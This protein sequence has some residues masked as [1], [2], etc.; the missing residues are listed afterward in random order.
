MHTLRNVNQLPHWNL[1]T[2]A[3]RG[4]VVFVLGTAGLYIAD[5]LLAGNLANP[6]LSSWALFRSML[7]LTAPV[8]LL[9]LDHVI[10]RYPRRPSQLLALLAVQLCMT[11]ALAAVT[12]NALGLPVSETLL[13]AVVALAVLLTSGGFFRSQYR[14]SLALSTIQLWKFAFFIPI[15][16]GIVAGWELQPAT[17]AFAT[18]G[19]WSVA[20][21]V[22]M[23]RYPVAKSEFS[24]APLS[25]L[26]SFGIRF[27]ATASL[28]SVIAFVDQLIL[29]LD[30]SAAESA[31]YFS[32]AAAVLPPFLALA[33]LTAN[34]AN[35]YLRAHASDIRSRVPRLLVAFSV[36]GI[37]GLTGSMFSALVLGRLLGA[38]SRQVDSALL[39]GLLGVGLMR[40]LYVA[41]SAVIGMYG[42]QRDLDRQ[43]L[44][45][46]VSMATGALGYVGSRTLGISSSGAVLIF[47]GVTLLGRNVSG[48]LI[49]ARILGSERDL[50]GA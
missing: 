45:T 41:P 29:N 20:A 15:A 33:G 49:S 9:G 12:L 48:A 23:I 26:Y 28:S 44:F 11:I 21:L 4:T 17:V 18:L 7:F 2:D 6:D 43:L 50:V 39:F 31:V 27:W 46:V 25:Q 22:L 34:Y 47:L 30:G 32:Y 37:L 5:L 42:T 40:Y 13:A 35:P 8:V 3:A 1:R 19:A 36:G 10:V 14:V 38:I 24:P 16:L